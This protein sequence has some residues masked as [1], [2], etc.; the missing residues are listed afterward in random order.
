LT[1][2]QAAPGKVSTTFDTWTADNTK[3]SFLGMTA[4]WIKVTKKEDPKVP[5]M[6]WKEEWKLRSEV[7]VFRGIVGDHSGDNLG[8]YLL[9]AL[10]CDNASNSSTG[11]KTVQS[12]HLR[13]GLYW[14]AEEN[15]LPCFKHVIN[16]GNVAVMG[17]ITRMAALQTAATIWDYDPDLPSNRVLGGSLDVIAAV[18]TLTVKI[19]SSGQRIEYFEKL[20]RECGIKTPLK[21]RFH[22]NV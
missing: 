6:E 1:E 11:T 18:R 14:D 2:K 9:Y 22:S 21:L 13:N 5:A 7:I 20:Q 16:L 8:H 15:Q 3:G 4:H 17:H 10:T 19:Q 12:Q